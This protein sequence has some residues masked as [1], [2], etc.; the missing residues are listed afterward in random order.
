MQTKGTRNVL[1]APPPP[2]VPSSSQRDNGNELQTGEIQSPPPS[3][4][5]PS[6]LTD[7][8]VST[9]G[10]EFTSR[11]QPLLGYQLRLPAWLGYSERVYH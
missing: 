11:G 9:T 10:Y 1:C 4:S 2:P 8:G 6:F 3:Y 7:E 5:H